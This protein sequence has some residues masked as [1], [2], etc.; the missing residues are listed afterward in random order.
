MILYSFFFRS[1]TSS[2]VN[3]GPFRFTRQ[4]MAWGTSRALSRRAMPSGGDFHHYHPFV[5]GLPVALHIAHGFQ[6]LQHRGQGP[7]IQVQP[8]SQVTHGDGLFFPEHHH[9]HILGVGEPDFFQEGG[10]GSHD[11]PGAGIQ[12]KAEL[13]FQ[14]QGIAGILFVHIDHTS[15]TEKLLVALYCNRKKT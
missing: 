8:F 7:G 4:P 2:G 10:I 1:S 11:L 9:G 15:G 14:K 3:R 13:V 5:I 6:L 12:G